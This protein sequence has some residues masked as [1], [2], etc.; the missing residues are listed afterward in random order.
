VR[1]VI[2]ALTGRSV[3]EWGGG[4]EAGGG[5]EALAEPLTVGKLAMTWYSTILAGEHRAPAR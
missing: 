3:E 2:A 1:G 4:V 5:E